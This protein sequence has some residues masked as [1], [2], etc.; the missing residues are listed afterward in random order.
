MSERLTVAGVGVTLLGGVAAHILEVTPIPAKPDVDRMI[1]VVCYLEFSEPF[2][3]VSRRLCLLVVDI[4]H[5][6][7]FFRSKILDWLDKWMVI[8]YSC[9]DFQNFDSVLSL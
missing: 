8:H 3:Q 6:T 1:A 4:T 7:I 5:L 2:S 9:V